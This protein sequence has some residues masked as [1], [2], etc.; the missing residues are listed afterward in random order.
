MAEEKT[1]KSAKQQSDAEQE[2][3]NKPKKTKLTPK[4]R[5][6]TACFVILT[7]AWAAITF[8][9]SQYIIGLPMVALLGERF[10]SPLWTCIYEALVYTLTLLF[11]IVFPTMIF[12]IYRK[13]HPKVPATLEKEVSTTPNE[14]GVQHLPT[15]VDIG[16]APIGYVVYLMI[17]QLLT[18]L[19]QIFPWFNP[20]QSQDVGFSYF[21]TGFDR[22]IAMVALVIIAPI[23]E[24]LIMRG[25]LYGKLRSRLKIP[26]AMILVSALFG[27]LHGQWNIAISTFALSLILCSLREITGTIW[28]GTL[29]HILSNGIAFYLLYVVM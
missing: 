26:L 19:M 18:Q 13:S 11:V 2:S 23:A 4:E 25:W 7:L 9:A 15:F 24:E 1:R 28:A 3:Q 27:L 17:A 21:V 8:I 6:Q 10:S 14:L 5:K 22:F 29:L 16:L 12:K 20:D